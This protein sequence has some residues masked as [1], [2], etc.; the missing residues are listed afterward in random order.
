MEAPDQVRGQ[1]RTQQ[2][3]HG[4]NEGRAAGLSLFVLNGCTW[5]YFLINYLKVSEFE[6]FKLCFLF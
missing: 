1:H 3:R 6:C 5:F 2:V 4:V